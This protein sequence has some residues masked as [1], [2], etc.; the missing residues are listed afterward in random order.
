MKILFSIGAGLICISF[1]ALLI[2]SIGMVGYVQADVRSLAAQRSLA[3]PFVCE[4]SIHEAGYGRIVLGT[5]GI[6][7]LLI[8]FRR[9][10]LWAWVCLSI[11]FFVYFIPVFLFPPGTSFP[12]AHDLWRGVSHPGLPRLMLLNALFPVLMILGLSA[13]LPSFLRS[14]E[15]V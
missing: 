10:E 7:I 8:P 14:K 3:Y 15:R 12:A 9:L 5:L 1:V 4:F 6:L 11:M 13:S 2:S